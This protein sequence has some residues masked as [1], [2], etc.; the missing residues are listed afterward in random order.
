MGI[1]RAQ[2][3]RRALFQGLIV[4]LVW[5]ALARAAAL[6]NA[7]VDRVA[8]ACVLIQAAE[9]QKAHSGSGFFVGANDVVT[10]YHVVS[11][12]AEGRAGILLVVGTNPRRRQVANADMVAADE[13]L[14]LA[15]LRTE[16][17]AP[18][19]LRFAS[20][21]ALKLTQPLW[22]AGF[23]FGTQAGLEVTMTAGTLSALRRDDAGNLLAI[24]MDAS[25]NPGNSGGPVVDARGLVVGVTRSIVNPKVG[26]G[27]AYAIPCNVAEKFVRQ[28]VRIRLRKGRVPVR[29]TP[30]GRSVRILA[31]QK[32][33]QAWGTIVRLTV[34]GARLTDR[35]T[36]FAIAVIDRKRQILGTGEIDPA[37]IPQRQ[38]KVIEIRLRG[39]RYEE[40]FGCEVTD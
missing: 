22:A 29:G 14:D 12:A 13:D 11:A 28:S 26:S 16:A 17:R 8:R 39:V 38:Q 25:I 30:P 2:S 7:V 24:Q 9:G 35:A 6:S 4:V 27:M 3:P 23:P 20:E 5:C 37:Q 15:L 32:A 21:R 33:Q 34:R 1:S 31:A 19:T 36:P 18:A 10:N 40:V